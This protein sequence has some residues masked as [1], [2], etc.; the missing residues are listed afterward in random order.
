MAS[1]ELKVI[2]HG[3]VTSAL[4]RVVDVERMARGKSPRWWRG[5]VTGHQQLVA[6]R[7]NPQRS[8]RSRAEWVYELCRTV[9]V[10]ATEVGYDLT[11]PLHRS[12]GCWADILMGVQLAAEEHL[13]V[14][15]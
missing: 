4:W 9:E 14:A 15:I 3:W 13:D 5:G 11:T 10:V 8:W 12:D 7:D 2:G 6:P 1:D